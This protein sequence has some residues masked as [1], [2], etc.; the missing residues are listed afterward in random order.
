MDYNVITWDVINNGIEMLS[1]E[2]I[3][4]NIK[5]EVIY[6][7]PRGGLIP[8]VMLSHKLRIP[9]VL[10]MEE[11][12]R[13]DMQHGKVLIVDDISDTGKTLKYFDDKNFDI[14]TIFVRMHTSK[15]SPKFN[16]F[17]INDDT[18]LLFPWETQDT[19]QS[20]L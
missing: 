3:S 7:P 11:V 15:I 8:G 6:G 13:I 1:K 18:W 19:T 20:N 16:A 17:D 9:L 10:N 12:W 5:Y 2:I 14:A 4:S